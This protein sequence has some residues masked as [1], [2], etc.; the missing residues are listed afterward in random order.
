MKPEMKSS[1]NKVENIV[2]GFPGF[3]YKDK[4]ITNI[5]KTLKAEED[6]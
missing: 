2:G 6:F 3:K 4:E 1:I 5:S